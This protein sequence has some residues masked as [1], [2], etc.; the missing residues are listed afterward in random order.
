MEERRRSDGGDMGY[1]A[2]GR[3]F[4]IGYVTRDL[5]VG[6]AYLV[7]V[8]G[9]RRLTRFDDVRAL[10]GGPS[11]IQRL[12]HFLLGGAEAELIEP[13][14][15]WPG[16]IYREAVDAADRP[17][18]LHHV[19]YLFATRED[20]RDA[21]EQARGRGVDI[22]SHADTADVGFAYLD[23]RSLVGHYTELVF[24]GPGVGPGGARAPR[25]PA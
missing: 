25:D 4:Q 7:D 16:S 22:P 3:H 6:T 11:S 17:I 8:L 14:S 23:T 21:V 2:L 5:E 19:G 13:R 15:S 12:S 1:L 9:A 20:F 24:R 18:A 10:D